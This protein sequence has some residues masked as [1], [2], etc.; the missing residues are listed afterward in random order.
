M[1]KQIIIVINIFLMI[2]SFLL[3]LREVLEAA[4]IIG[5]VLGA[6]NKFDRRDL[7]PSVWAGVAVAFLF[8]L[9]TALLL[10]RLSIAFQGIAEQLFEGFAMLA[11]AVL[12]SWMI[13]WM[14]S[15][16]SSLQA[17]LEGRTLAALGGRE[18]PVIF[19][20]IFFAVFRE[21]VELALFLLAARLAEGSQNQLTGVLLGLAFSAALGLLFFV[22]TRGLALRRFFQGASP[23]R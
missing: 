21:R 6:L 14:R 12:L 16:A 18:K 10:I 20:L 15:H 5:I 7:Y 11:A 19:L 3:S 4:L 9:G 13:H 2:S 1:I 17:E 23:G 8:S 22:L